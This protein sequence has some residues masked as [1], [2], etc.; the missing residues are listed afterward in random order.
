MNKN[1][2]FKKCLL[3]M[4]VASSVVFAS[5]ALAEEA[6]L[7]QS[8][9]VTTGQELAMSNVASQSKV[10]LSNI[11]TELN[12][13]SQTDDK[14]LQDAPQE[15][16]QN[17]LLDVLVQQKID[18]FLADHGISNGFGKSAD[19]EG[20]IGFGAAQIVDKPVSHAEYAKYRVMAY[21]KAYEKALKTFIQDNAVMIQAQ[22]LSELYT[23]ASTPMPPETVLKEGK[24][25]FGALWDKVVALADSE[26]SGM[27][28]KNGV[29]PKQYNARNPDQKKEL[30][31][32]MI[33]KKEVANIAKTL[34]GLTVA[35][36]FFEVNGEDSAVGVVIFYSPKTQAL[37]ESLR[38]GLKPAI[39]NT[40]K[41]LT[42]LLP[43]N[44]PAKL[45]DMI[46]TRL[47]V[48]EN[49]PVIVSFG[50]WANASTANSQSVKA[51][52]R[53]AAIRQ[54][55]Q[56]SL[57]QIASFLNLSFSAKNET[58]RSSL[59]VEAAITD[60]DTGMITNESRSQI[61]DIVREH[62]RTR[63][64]ELL[65]GARTL[66]QWVYI[67]PQGQ[68]VVGVIKAYSFASMQQAINMGKK[69]INSNNPNTTNS[70]AGTSSRQGEVVTDFNVF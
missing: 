37:A 36:T 6:V 7:G 39:N 70:A 9:P 64:S 19:T 52:Y 27:L 31:R 10:D 41:A 56:M 62:S 61:V 51:R 59:L 40:G 35:Q 66:K 60:G 28:E 22:T 5:E 46:G 4:I 24:G 25:S 30:I 58:E 67:T 48:D 33:A 68:E 47:L 34:S 50:Q 2:Q 54:A 12:D 21:E 43:L 44:E 3:S 42:D 15:V 69:T 17:V 29:D 38:A 11:G 32:D 49:G 16:K 63:A 18:N 55:D 8:T 26:V 13:V 57:S 20:K 1:L 53:N 14:L 65:R 23:D 45:Y